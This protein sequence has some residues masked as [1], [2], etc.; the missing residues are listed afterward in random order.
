ML[1][2]VATGNS[3]ATHLSLSGGL[4]RGLDR[5]RESTQLQQFDALLLGF[6]RADQVLQLETA[7]SGLSCQ[8]RCVCTDLLLK[9]GILARRVLDGLCAD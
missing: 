4:A 3:S 8:T 9:I 7:S 1:A 5:R 2:S 6:L